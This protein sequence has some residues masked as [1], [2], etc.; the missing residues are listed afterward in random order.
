MDCKLYSESGGF[1]IPPKKTTENWGHIFFYGKF[2]YTQFFYAKIFLEQFF[3][4][5]IV[6]I[7]LHQNFSNLFRSVFYTKILAIF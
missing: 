7:F 2:F 6:C 1:F 3:Y 4:T 5:K